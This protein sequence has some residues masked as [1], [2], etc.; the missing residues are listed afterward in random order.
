VRVKGGLVR[1][2]FEKHEDR[3]LTGV[4]EHLI[5]PVPGFGPGGF[6]HLPQ[7]LFDPVFFARP[8]PVLGDDH[9]FHRQPL[10]LTIAEILSP[11]GGSA[12]SSRRT[13]KVAPHAADL[14]VSASQDDDRR[15]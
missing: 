5:V 2:S 6:H 7:G 9:E 14:S 8:C 10:M 12:E 11:P 1:V 13:S 15:A 3:G 4:A